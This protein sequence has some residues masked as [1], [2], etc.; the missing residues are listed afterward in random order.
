MTEQKP[1]VLA[2]ILS[3]YK[4]NAKFIDQL[5]GNQIK[6]IAGLQ[7]GKK[8]HGELSK[9]DSGTWNALVKKYDELMAPAPETPEELMESLL[10]GAVAEYDA[11]LASANDIT[12]PV[13]AQAAS[14]DLTQNVAPAPGFGDGVQVIEPI[15][16]V[17]QSMAEKIARE[18]CIL[19]VHRSEP[20]FQKKIDSSI[21]LNGPNEGVDPKRLYVTKALVDSKEIKELSKHRTKFFDDLKA[22]SLPSGLLTIGNGQYLISVA[23]VT[24][25][26]QMIDTYLSERS[27]LLDDFEFRYPDIIKAAEERLGP[28]FNA[29]DY[30]PFAQIRSGYSTSYRF[31]S[32]TV[33]EEIEKIS[34]EIYESEQK[35][36][37]H[38]CAGE[39]DFIQN[40]LRE[41]FLDLV[42][43]FSS[44]LGADEET[45]KAKRFHGSNIDHLKEF[46][47]TF[48]QMNL[49]GDMVLE[50]L[51][52][53]AEALVTDVDPTKVRTDAEFRAEL[54]KSF[55]DIKTAADKLVVERKRKVIL[56]D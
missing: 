34:K 48:K 39:V 30:P 31:V 29:G 14:I 50:E 20:G 18:T 55:N 38:L 56:E 10:P 16:T 25:I 28:L 17:S 54:E 9:K 26:K 15:Q 37:L 41:R 22:M 5:S 44:R 8:T 33:P 35:R 32:N 36:I 49:T 11:V 45:G 24:Q 23:M 1:T 46:V 40:T 51:V 3:A 7:S 19:E 21:V 4:T 13:I 43:H 12:P 47:A 53:K 52:H 42:E 6:L 2:G 27:A